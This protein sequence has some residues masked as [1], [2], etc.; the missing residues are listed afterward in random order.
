MT[1]A[2]GIA[3]VEAY[4]EPPR[5]IDAMREYCEALDAIRGTSVG[6]YFRERGYDCERFLLMYRS[7]TMNWSLPVPPVVVSNALEDVARYVMTP[8]GP[9]QKRESIDSLRLLRWLAHRWGL[10]VSGVDRV[11][12][13]YDATT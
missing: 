9:N 7:F 12:A 8:Q 10:N 1:E 2:E 13:A 11:I 6:W 3:I 5:E 4:G